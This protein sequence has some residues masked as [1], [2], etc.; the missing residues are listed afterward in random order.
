M[1]VVEGQMISSPVSFALYRSCSPRGLASPPTSYDWADRCSVS[2]SAL[3]SIQLTAYHAGL[4]GIDRSPMAVPDG[5]NHRRG[6]GQD[7]G[8][9]ERGLNLANGKKPSATR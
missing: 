2:H 7:R 9:G 6:Y 5:R 8:W 1:D 3:D 4:Y